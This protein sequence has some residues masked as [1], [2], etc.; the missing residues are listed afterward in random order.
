MFSYSSLCYCIIVAGTSE[1]LIIS[2]N[3]NV[4]RHHA[5]MAYSCYCML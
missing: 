3:V 1:I 5:C 2:G 4:A